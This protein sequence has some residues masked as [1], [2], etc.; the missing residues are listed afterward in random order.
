MYVTCKVTLIAWLW[1]VHVLWHCS[2][3]LQIICLFSYLCRSLAAVCQESPNFTANL[4]IFLLPALLPSWFMG[5]LYKYWVTVWVSISQLNTFQRECQLTVA[6]RGG[7]HFQVAMD[8]SYHAWSTQAPCWPKGTSSQ[9]PL[10]VTSLMKFK[11]YDLVCLII[12]F[13]DIFPPL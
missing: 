1:P 13:L 6:C 7:S 11:I 8:T 5:K 4:S 12:S 9:A 2:W 3:S 10:L